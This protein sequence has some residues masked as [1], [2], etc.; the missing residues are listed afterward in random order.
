LCRTI[1]LRCDTVGHEG[2]W[3]AHILAPAIRPHLDQR[4]PNRASRGDIHS[5]WPL[6]STNQPTGHYTA[7]RERLDSYAD[8]LT[9]TID[10]DPNL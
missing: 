9:A 4:R 2:R 7:L 8:K 5:R 3:S 6:I 10:R 1:S